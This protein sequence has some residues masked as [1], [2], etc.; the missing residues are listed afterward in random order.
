MEICFM[1]LSAAQL[2]PRSGGSSMPHLLSGRG[3]TTK[4]LYVFSILIRREFSNIQGYQHVSSIS[5][6][7][8]NLGSSPGCN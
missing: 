2:T 5:N 6:A 1:V 4:F 7:K 3:P 8:S